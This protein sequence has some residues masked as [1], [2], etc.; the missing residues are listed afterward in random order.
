[1]RVFRAEIR[2]QR[3]CGA[4]SEPSDRVLFADEI[5]E[6]TADASELSEPPVLLL[7][8]KPRGIIIKWARC[9]VA[10]DR[11]S[12]VRL[13]RSLYAQS[14]LQAKRGRASSLAERPGLCARVSH[15]D[16]R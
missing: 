5:G 14:Q 15:G 12:R 10:S 9:P 13:V 7:P 11:V 16:V 4:A 1:M 2:A 8:R 6:Q 3:R